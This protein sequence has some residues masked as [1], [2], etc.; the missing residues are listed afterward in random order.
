MENKEVRLAI[1]DAQIA[2][3]EEAVKD[4]SEEACRIHEQFTEALQDITMLQNAADKRVGELKAEK[5]EVLAEGTEV[6]K[7]L[8]ETE[9][10]L[11]SLQEVLDAAQSFVAQNYWMVRDREWPEAYRKVAEL[12]GSLSNVV[13]ALED[14]KL[15]LVRKLK[16]DGKG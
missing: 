2:N 8:A 12:G 9:E 11:A 6:S 5:E 13:R 14:R 15:W 1:L 4:L 7:R 16:E 3:A 10:R